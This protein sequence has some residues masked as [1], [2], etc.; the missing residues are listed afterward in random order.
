MKNKITQFKGI[1]TLQSG[2]GTSIYDD[3]QHTKEENDSHICWSPGNLQYED[4]RKIH[5]DETVFSAHENEQGNR[6]INRNLGKLLT[7]RSE[8]VLTRLH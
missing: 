5:K 2:F 1:Q 6:D 4:I 3:L 8:Q 7:A